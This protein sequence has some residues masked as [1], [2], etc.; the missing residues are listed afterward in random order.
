MTIHIYF[1]GGPMDGAIQSFEDPGTVIEFPTDQSD[2]YIEYAQYHKVRVEDAAGGVFRGKQGL[3][4][5]RGTKIEALEDG[6]KYG[7][8]HTKEKS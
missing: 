1:A 7:V 2:L 5:Y 4:T 6:K 8:R 3:W